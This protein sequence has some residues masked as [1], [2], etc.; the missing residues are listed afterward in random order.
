MGVHRVNELQPFLV[1][2]PD[3]M[4]LTGVGRTRAYELVGTGEWP[5]VRLGR[6]VLIPVEGLKAWAEKMQC[7]E[8]VG[9]AK[10]EAK[11]I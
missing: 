1:K 10:C 5:S 2:I 11:P 7:G 3:A 8:V 4:K 9:E 6:R